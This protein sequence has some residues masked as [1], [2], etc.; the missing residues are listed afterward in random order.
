MHL[1]KLHAGNLLTEEEL[2]DQSLNAMKEKNR[3]VHF[4][5]LPVILVIMEMGQSAGNH[6]HQ[7]SVT[8]VHSA[9]SQTPMEEGLAM[10]SGKK[11]NVTKITTKVVKR[12][13]PSGIQDVGQT[14][15]QL[16]AVSV[17]PIAHQTRTIS[18]SHVKRG[19][20]A[21]EL[22]NLSTALVMNN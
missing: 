4:A 8:K 19:L 1:L 17:R 16:D 2:A 3:T 20:M 21:E 15:M 22:E 6:V 7:V 11:I 12:M 18:V 5:T 9:E 13:V 14:S 10:S